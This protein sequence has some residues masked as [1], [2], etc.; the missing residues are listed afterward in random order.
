MGYNPSVCILQGLR[1]N[2]SNDSLDN[3]LK[4]LQVFQP[5]FYQHLISNYENLDEIR[6]NFYCNLNFNQLPNGYYIM[7]NNSYFYVGI[8]FYCYNVLPSSDGEVVVSL[9][10]EEDISKFKQLCTDNN[11]DISSFNTYLF[12]FEW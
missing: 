5:I 1:F 6:D 10:S 2:I 9:P 7:E 11:I 3:D 4:I 8:F 12:T